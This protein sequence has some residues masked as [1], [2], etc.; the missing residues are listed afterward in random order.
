MFTKLLNEAT[1]QRFVELRS[2]VHTISRRNISQTYGVDSLVGVSLSKQIIPSPV[3]TGKLLVDI[4]KIIKPNQFVCNLMHVGR[5]KK[6]A[7]AKMSGNQCAIISPAFTVFEVNEP[8]TLLPE[9]LI[10]WFTQAAFDREVS[11]M[12]SEGIRDGI[13]WGTFARIKILIPDL[14][15]Q[16]KIACLYANVQHNNQETQAL[17]ELA[18]NYI[19]TISTI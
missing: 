18:A 13:K 10:A 11:Y 12:A 3:N 8:Q 15:S 17:C 19:A 14:K 4:Y 16:E 9:Y 1:N 6:V 5:D 2:Q 7:I